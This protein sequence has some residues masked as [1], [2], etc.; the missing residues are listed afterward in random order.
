[1]STISWNK[2]PGRAHSI[3]TGFNWKPIGV[4][5]LARDG[6]AI[7]LDGTKLIRPNQKK[8]EGESESL[9][10]DSN[11]NYNN[12][13]KWRSLILRWTGDN[14]DVVEFPPRFFSFVAVAVVAGKHIKVRNFKPA[15]APCVKHVVTG[16]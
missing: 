8:G 15:V 14:S 5:W 10:I 3:G 13:K 6:N 7:Q 12:K 1:M 2:R 16:S 11:N 4:D 9:N